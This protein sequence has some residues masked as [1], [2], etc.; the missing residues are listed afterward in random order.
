MLTLALLGISDLS[1]TKMPVSK[2][3]CSSIRSNHGINGNIEN[4]W[5][6]L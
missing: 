6:L 4:G 1:F 3:I 2:N 5:F